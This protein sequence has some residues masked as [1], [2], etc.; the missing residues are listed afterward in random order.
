MV[1]PDTYYIPQS[2]LIE[3]KRWHR[4][5]VYFHWD[6]RCPHA[7]AAAAMK[8]IM[9]NFQHASDWGATH[10]VATNLTQ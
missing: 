7:E 9:G 3:A 10:R 8:R 5:A 4:A 2:F 1:H 6:P